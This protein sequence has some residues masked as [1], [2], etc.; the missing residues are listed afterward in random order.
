MKAIKII[1]L[2]GL[3]TLGAFGYAKY[4][5]TGFIPVFAK[6]EEPHNTAYDLSSPKLPSKEVDISES[7]LT[8][9]DRNTVIFRSEVSYE[10]VAKL[11]QE[12]F[13]KAKEMKAGE[14]LYLVLDTPGGDINAG[15]GLVD[16]LRAL[17]VNVKTITNFSASMGFYIAQRLGER[18][19]TPHGMFM[20]HRARVGG[21]GGQIPGE[22]ITATGRLLDLVY[23]ME[24]ENAARMGISHEAYTKLVKDE[25]WVSG[26]DA[27]KQG[28]ADKV[29]NIRC[30]DDLQGEYSE[31]VQVFMFT[32]QIT[33]SKCPAIQGPLSIGMGGDVPE[34]KKQELIKLVTDRR[35][36]TRAVNQLQ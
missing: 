17:H 11:Q 4:K 33:W 30:A 2:L 29:V 26:V 25:Y 32:L 3:I 8:L 10:S 12:I 35:A 24:R 21:V 36:L 19:V 22:F 15:N 7:V 28:V 27:V 20:A 9:K 14:T 31:S 16:S 18:L 34:E 6:S 13:A 1:A 23:G 5:A